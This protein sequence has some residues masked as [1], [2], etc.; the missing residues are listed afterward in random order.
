MMDF[1]MGPKAATSWGMVDHK[2][3]NTRMDP[4]PEGEQDKLGYDL[5]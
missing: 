2:R 3:N 5:R 1:K 4:E